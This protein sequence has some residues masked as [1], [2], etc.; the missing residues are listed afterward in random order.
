MPLAPPAFSTIAFGSD[1][2]PSFAAPPAFASRA[3]DPLFRPP[4]AAPFSFMQAPFTFQARPGPAPSMQ[5]S[6]RAGPSAP[7]G[8]N[9]FTAPSVASAF[10][11]TTVSASHSAGPVFTQPSPGLLP[12]L[13]CHMAL[14]VPDRTT[15]GSMSTGQ[16]SDAFTSLSHPASET[17]QSP[18]TETTEVFLDEGPSAHEGF[19]AFGS[20]S[21]RGHSVVFSPSTL[22]DPQ[23]FATTQL[24]G[25]PLLHTRA[26]HAALE[27][28]GYVLEERVPP[29]ER[30]WQ[31]DLSTASYLQIAAEIPPH[32]IIVLNLE[33]FQ[34]FVSATLNERIR[35]TRGM[36]IRATSPSI[37]FLRS[38]ISSSETY[39]T[40]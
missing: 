34:R 36:L 8:S 40:S 22:I 10:A 20:P 15:Q 31:H 30:P 35:C 38:R 27:G 4:T 33:E 11:S 26:L 9:I 32:R 28:M 24:E 25:P 37:G 23:I 12:P 17:G 19:S 2:S 6:G 5:L 13:V 18:W 29:A 39:R 7:G 21:A 14:T 3:G 1:S 16:H